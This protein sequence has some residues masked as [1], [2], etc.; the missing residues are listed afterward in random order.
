[1]ITCRH[2]AGQWNK[3]QKPQPRCG[4]RGTDTHTA[5]QLH[6][7]GTGEVRSGHRKEAPWALLLLWT[8]RGSARRLPIGQ[9]ANSKRHQCGACPNELSHTRCEGLHPGAPHKAH[10]LPQCGLRSMHITHDDNNVERA[11]TVTLP[12]ERLPGPGAILKALYIFTQCNLYHDITGTRYGH[13]GSVQGW[14]VMELRVAFQ[15]SGRFGKL[16]SA[17]VSLTAF[18]GENEISGDI[19]E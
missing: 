7:V 9:R 15:N 3:R 14:K 10:L 1:M 2:C 5:W 19:N 13:R 16:Q 17:S 4:V 12:R 8:Y 18:V 11:Q 6:T